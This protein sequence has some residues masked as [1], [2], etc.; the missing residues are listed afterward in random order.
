MLSR[1]EFRPLPSLI[2]LALLALL[3]WLGTWQ[4]SRADEKRE[5]LRA[6]DQAQQTVAWQ[7]VNNAPP[8][9]TQVA[10]RGRYDEAHQVLLDGVRRRG[11]AGVEILTPL[12]TDNGAT[13]MV[14]RG[15]M[16]WA[17]NRSAPATPPAPSDP[18]TV[19]GRVR[20][21]AQPGMRLGEGNASI[22]QTW[23][24][25]AIYPSGDEIAQWLGTTISPVL[26]LLDAQAPHGFERVWRPDEFP[27]SRHVGYAV[28]WYS[29]AI[30]LVV[31]FLI[32]CRKRADEGGGQ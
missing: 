23:P 31:L 26:V 29:L 11:Q 32:A 17:G 15:W 7:D 27:P 28:Q 16:P 30:A 2:T 3:I 14:N 5:T 25:L 20:P 4:L 21:F 24:R 9:Y 6:F 22:A 10:V 19:T 12:R 18:V 1:F 8:R 13:V